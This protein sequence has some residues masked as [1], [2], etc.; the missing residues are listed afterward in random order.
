MFS[1]RRWFRKKAQPVKAPPRRPT[2]R[3]I[4]EALESR[5]LPSTGSHLFIGGEPMVQTKANYLHA[6]KYLTVDPANQSNPVFNGNDMT[7]IVKLE[8]PL[9]REIFNA[10]SNNPVRNFRFD[11]LDA[12][13]QN[14]ELRIDVITFM[15]EVGQQGNPAVNTLGLDFSYYGPN[16]PPSAN[17]AYWSVVPAPQGATLPSREF[18]YSGSD[19]YGAIM[20][21]TQAPYAGECEGTAEIAILYAAAQVMG[22]DAFNQ[23]FSTGLVFGPQL[24]GQ[25]SPSVYMVLPQDQQL[26]AGNKLPGYVHVNTITTQDMVPGDWVYMKNTPKYHG[27]YLNGENAIYMGQYDSVRNG[28][29][30]WRVGATPR[31]TGLGVTITNPQTGQWEGQTLAN[32]SAAQLAK[33]LWDGYTGNNSPVPA[34]S[35]IGWTIDVGPGTTPY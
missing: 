11:D 4:C 19:A 3:P 35:G 30:V 21:I 16:N 14:F 24:S 22:P 20:S 32:L 18:Q 34:G 5:D 8:D 25:P 15:N 17:S 28:M 29:P 13:E 7:A 9:R 12:A 1:L 2:L 26:Y 27:V 6:I 23:L 31:F 33:E 10:M